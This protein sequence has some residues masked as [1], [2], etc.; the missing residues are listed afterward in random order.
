[1]FCYMEKVWESFRRGSGLN[2]NFKRLV[3]SSA[4][5]YAVGGGIIRRNSLEAP[6]D[7]GS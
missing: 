3:F 7:A 5:K 4:G 2:Y 6:G 1:M